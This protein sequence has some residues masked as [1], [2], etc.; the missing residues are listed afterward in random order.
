[1]TQSYDF[2]MA[3]AAEAATEAKAATLDNVRI[4]AL[5]SE[6]VWRDMADREKRIS[7]EREKSRVEREARRAEELLAEHQVSES[8]A[9][10]RA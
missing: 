10:P 6:A 8:L 3:R 1:M 5:R 4:R 2:L 7:S 9:I